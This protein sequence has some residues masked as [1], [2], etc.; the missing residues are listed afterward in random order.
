MKIVAVNPR[1]FHRKAA[2]WIGVGLIFSA[3]TGMAFRLG[4][5]WFD[6]D[7]RKGGVLLSLHSWDWMGGWFS[8]VVPVLLGVGILLLLSTAVLMLWQT[9]K[10]LF[11][12]PKAL[13]LVHRL[14]GLV[15]LLPL[16]VSVVTGVAYRVVE[17]RD[18]SDETL[19]FLMDLHTGGWIGRGVSP[20]YIAVLGIAVLGLSFTG[21]KVGPKKH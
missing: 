6:L 21:W 10:K 9:R 7:S 4:R 16:A 19:D 18:G 14:L 2:P 8:L 15:L 5:S 11:Q 17:L 20:Y 12:S 13:R 3:L 1:V